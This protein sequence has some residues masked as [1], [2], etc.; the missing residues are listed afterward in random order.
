M[1]PVLDQILVAMVV[2][3]AIAYLILRMRRRRRAGKACGSG[4]CPP[5]DPRHRSLSK[6]RELMTK[7][8]DGTT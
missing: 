4:C 7:K 1:N 2:S 3:G 8:A 5:T 6:R